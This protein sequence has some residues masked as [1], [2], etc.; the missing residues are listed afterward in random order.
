MLLLQNIYMR[1]IKVLSVYRSLLLENRGTP[2]RVKSLIQYATRNAEIAWHTCTLDTESPLGLPHMTITHNHLDDIQKIY[3][4]VRRNQIDVVVFHSVAASFY[5]L[6]IKILTSAKVVL[7]MHGFRE[8]ENFLYDGLKMKY[9]RDKFIFGVFYRFCDLIT[10]CSISATE[11]LQTYNSNV[12]SVYGGVNLSLFNPDIQSGG[13]IQKNQ[14]D[15][16]VGYAGDGRKW[17]GLPFLL[18]AFEILV[19]KYPQYK[20]ALLLSEKRNIPK[21]DYIQVVEAL[22]HD[23]VSAFT[24]DCDVLV[25]PRIKSRVNELT[26]A[27]KFMEYM[28]MGKAV[29][30]SRTSDMHKIITDGENGLLFDPEDTEGFIQAMSTLT[31]ST[32]R[33]RLGTNA[34]ATA[35]AGYTWD[36]Q[37]KVFLDAIKRL[38]V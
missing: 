34:H 1:K 32:L 19:T 20:L 13:Y 9:Y 29:V 10:T 21:R 17:Q 25:L 30:V 24:I 15:I 22:P 5:L 11:Y 31:D 8:E 26:Y 27:S 18:E 36:I 4:Y 2:L 7:E 12:V 6:P 14:G 38:F 35:V 23:K 37:G 33:K 28:A 3:Q 16:I